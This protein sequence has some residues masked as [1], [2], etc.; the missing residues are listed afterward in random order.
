MS[1]VSYLHSYAITH[2]DLKPEN[3][4]L[5]P[6]YQVQLSDFG[7]AKIPFDATGSRF[8][9]SHTQDAGT[10]HYIG[11]EFFFA[12]TEASPHEVNQQMSGH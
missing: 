10:L 5:L 11:P 3:I 6:N 8:S 2:E 4:L 1:A 7:L 12:E 9:S